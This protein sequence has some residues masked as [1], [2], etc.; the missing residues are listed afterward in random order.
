LIKAFCPLIFT[1]LSAF[2]VA[3]VF[4][5]VT[6][7]QAAQI[8][9]HARAAL[10][11]QVAMQAGSWHL[12]ESQTWTAD[13]LEGT[14]RF[15]TAEGLNGTAKIQIIGSYS[16]VDQTFTWGW[17]HPVAT[18][19]L[20]QHAL[21]VRDWGRKAE[22]AALTNRRVPCSVEDAWNFAALTNHLAKSEGVFRGPSGVAW[23]FMTMSDVKIELVKSQ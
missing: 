13:F 17:D 10:D 11:Q 16:K 18:E 5:Q 7:E 22:L 15:R 6:K 9:A 4:A 21:L 2:T 20:K 23:V 14:L 12:G 8:F 1:A 3:P 19:P